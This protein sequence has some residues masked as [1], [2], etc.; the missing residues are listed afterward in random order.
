[1]W[2]GPRG[3]L[4]Q[5]TEA[6]RTLAEYVQLEY[7]PGEELWV[8]SELLRTIRS[9]PIE[10]ASNGGHRLLAWLRRLRRRSAARRP[11]APEPVVPT[12]P[13]PPGG[14]RAGHGDPRA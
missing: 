3:V 1:M 4:P 5:W 6:N 7:A 14:D 8:R 2:S 9:P 12:V 11:P 13:T 10:R